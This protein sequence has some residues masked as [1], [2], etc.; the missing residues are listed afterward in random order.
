LQVLCD[1][2]AVLGGRCLLALPALLPALTANLGSTHE[3]L[4]G[5]AAA[6]L[7]AVAAATAAQPQQLLLGLAQ[8]VAGSSSA[9]SRIAAAAKLQA[10]LPQVRTWLW[11]AA[12]RG[13]CCIKMPQR[14]VL[15]VAL[16][17]APA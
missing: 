6:S 1:V 17:E 3:R 12:A 2:A 16:S 8:A 14:A 7:D 5:C 10:M 13:A 9:R 4:R 11:R 15:P